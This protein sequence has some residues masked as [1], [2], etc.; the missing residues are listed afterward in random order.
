MT[1][2]TG[3]GRT[4][5]WRL[6]YLPE[7]DFTRPLIE[8]TEERQARLLERLRLLYGESTAAATVP[9]LIRLLKVHCAHKPAALVEAE[10]AFRRGDHFSE[11]DMMLITYGD[12]VRAQ[13]R[14]GLSALGEFLAAFR[15]GEPIFSILHVLPFFPYTSDR[16]FSVVDFRTVD[17]ALG[18]W[19]D[20]RTLGQT[21][22]LMFDGVLNHASSQS[23]PFREM[24]A[25][26]PDFRDYAVAF[27]SREELTPEQR[28][29]L[30]RPRTSDVLT[31][32]QS[33]D[34]PIWVWT[35]FSHDQIDLNYRNPRVLL[36]AIDT[37]LFYVRMGADLVRL[38]A[39]TYLWKELGTSSASLEQTHAI[40]K[41]F[42]DVLDVA[43]PQVVLVTESNVPHEENISY[44]GA[45]GDEAQ[46]VY[47]FALP[48]LV[49]HAF[50]RGD[51]S[52]L[53][54][55][56]RHLTYPTDGATYL[57][58]LDTHDGI[59]LSGVRDILPPEET[60]FLVETAR[61]HGAFISHRSGEEGETPYEINTTWYS[62]LNYQSD[63]EPQQL[64]VQR[65][66]ASR[67]IALVL[68]GVPAIYIHSLAGSRSD[69]RLAL[70]TG[71]KRDVNRAHIDLDTLQHDLADPSSRLTQL[72]QR[73]RPL[74]R[75]RV[76]S[77]AFHPEGRQQVLDLGASLFAVLRTSPS[78]DDHVVC[79]TNVT[80]AEQCVVV[81]QEDLGV[82]SHYWFDLV[83]GRGWL[84]SNGELRIE[85][86]P[87]DVLWITPSQELERRIET[88]RDAG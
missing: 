26:N 16:G 9:E 68:R 63:G 42:R 45:G 13:N 11:K 80:A 54:G 1:M 65:F 19:Q 72:S 64:Q 87:Y 2:Q 70:K 61:A 58:M 36:S 47:N 28:K 53:S 29:I 84:A 44:F 18:S 82:K 69:I 81:R 73:L 12:M 17:P 15:R 56:A 6:D 83:A 86:G 20:I 4:G 37:L 85:L 77:P 50:Y 21:F 52:W 38:D 32:F 41:L 24:L 3:S 79:V 57:N 51:T 43:A 10:Q 55:W 39:I 23:V 5:W 34:G 7:P 62:A 71:V 66:V 49:L 76:M 67:S 48:P 30:R 25:G 35:T 78:G 75:M 22:R 88:G 60:A 31:R 59:G 27:R 40:V 33:I 46:L 14:T 8:V 74:L